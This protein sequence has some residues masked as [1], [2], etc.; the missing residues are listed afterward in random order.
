MTDKTKSVSYDDAGVS[1]ERGNE[2]IKRISGSAAKTRQ[3]GVM[4]GLGGFGA[5]FDL[6][7]LDY[8]NPVLVSGTDGVGTKLKLAIETNR[9]DSIGIDLVAMCVND[10][11]VQGAKP[12]FFLDYFACSKLDVESASIVINGIAKGCE[13]AGCALVGGETAEM[14]GMYQKGDYDLAGFCVGAVEKDEIIDGSDIKDGDRII[15]LASSGPHSNG[16]SLIR[17]LIDDGNISHDTDINGQ[18][19]IDCLLQPTRI[20]TGA[21]LKLIEETKINGLAHIT[22]GGLTENIPRILP[23]NTSAELNESSIQLPAIFQ[24]LQQQGNIETREMYKTFNC[25]IGMV[26]IV[27]SDKEQA[28]I[29][30]L[31]ELG[32]DAW[33]LGRIKKSKNQAPVVEYVSQ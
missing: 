12:L 21:I 24:W 7:S 10:L 6:S 17:K 25:G 31:K 27:A 5:L 30:K 13:L 33:S 20:Y 4:S 2:L 11:I 32:E 26:L 28:C 19:L 23:D 8:K 1:V 15:A 3:K 18:A 14:P 29:N 16:Y 9:H 22:G